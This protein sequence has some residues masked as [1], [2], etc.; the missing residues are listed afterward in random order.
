MSE[1]AGVFPFPGVAMRCREG[2]RFLRLTETLLQ[3]AGTSTVIGGRTVS[4]RHVFDEAA[5]FSAGLINKV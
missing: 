3:P 1:P 2:K 5:R 4:G